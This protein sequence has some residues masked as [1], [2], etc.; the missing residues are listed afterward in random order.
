MVKTITKVS[1]TIVTAL[2]IMAIATSATS[3]VQVKL[4]ESV[5]ESLVKAV[6]RIDTN[7]DWVVKN[8]RTK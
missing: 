6:N 7:L 5:I 2:I 4:N 1:V 3:I 8:M